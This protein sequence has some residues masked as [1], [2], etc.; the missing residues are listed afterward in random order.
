MES[1]GTVQAQQ[2]QEQLASLIL[3][4]LPDFGPGRYWRLRRHFSSSRAMLAAP[5]SELGGILSESACEQLLAYQRNPTGHPLAEQAQ[6]D[7]DWLASNKVVLLTP[8]NPLYPALLKPVHPA[9]PLLFVQGCVDNLALPQL[10]IVGSRNPT[11]TG[12]SNAFEFARQLARTGF[13]VTSGLALGIDGAAHQGALAA[14]GKTIAVLGTGIDRIYPHRHRG[15][16]GQ[17]LAEGGTLVS[18]FPLGSA[19]QAGNFPRRNRIISG[20]SLGVLVV[21]AALRSGSLISAKYAM[22]QGREVFAIP[23]SIHN[24][25]SRGC[26]ALLREGATLVEQVDDLREPLQGLLAFKWAEAQ[27]VPQAPTPLKKGGLSKEEQW[28]LT[29]IGYEDTSLDT[30]LDRTGLDTGRALSLLTRLELQ[31][32]IQQ[33]PGGYQRKA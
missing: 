2:T 7:L 1:E 14:R 18:E 32:L 16:A 10:A 3:S 13:A 22:Q 27:P 29:N 4:R 21:E 20:L 24:P 9:P 26:H 8:E 31:G 33:M 12:K 5:V 30:L 15:L 17:L 28:I 6:Q 23:G 19:P 25:L 11:P